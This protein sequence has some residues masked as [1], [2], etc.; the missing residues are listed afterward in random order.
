[1]PT[2]TFAGFGRALALPLIMSLALAGCGTQEAEQ[3]GQ[4]ETAMTD[5]P[6]VDGGAV[7][8]GEA[9][10]EAAALA[11]R[12]SSGDLEQGEL[13]V[14][15]EDLDRLVN[16]NPVDFPE[17]RRPSL[18]EDI[19]SARMAMES[20]DSEALQEAAASIQATLSGSDAATTA[21]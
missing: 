8:A 16:D 7:T 21:S 12:I 1:M 9:R 3:V 4:A 11:E 20:E 18:T 15:L 5:E 19:Q 6:G 2:T 14:A 10:S 13:S 17:D